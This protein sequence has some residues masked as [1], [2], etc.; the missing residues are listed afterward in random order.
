M[1]TTH[2][3]RKVSV[4]D[5]LTNGLP[6]GALGVYW[7]DTEWTECRAHIEDDS[8][9]QGVAPSDDPTG[10]VLYDLVN[11]DAHRETNQ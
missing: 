3:D 8:W 10:L 5:V 7:A 1:T 11:C 6:E 4:N 9:R 2:T